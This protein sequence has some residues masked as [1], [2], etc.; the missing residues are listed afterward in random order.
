VAWKGGAE[1]NDMVFDAC[2]KVNS[3]EIGTTRTPD[4]IRMNPTI[5]IS[6]SFDD[7]FSFDYREMLV[8]LSYIIGCL[9][10]SS[11][12]ARRPVF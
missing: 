6:M 5:P 4:P 1:L 7:A 12:K 2:L 10:L 11:K 9:P 3:N 8:T